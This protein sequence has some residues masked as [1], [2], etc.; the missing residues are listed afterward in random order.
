MLVRFLLAPTFK[1]QCCTYP[2]RVFS[3]W[4]KQ[5]GF[6]VKFHYKLNSSLADCDVLCI[7]HE[8]LDKNPLNPRPPDRYA[9]LEEFSEK[10]KALIWFDLS[11]STGTTQ[12]SVIP[13]VDLYAKNQLLKD[14]SLYLR[15][16]TE[17]R[18]FA[19]YYKE[20]A[21]V[22]AKKKLDKRQPAKSIELKKLAVSWNIGMGDIRRKP[23][24]ARYY[25]A[26]VP[27]TRYSKKTIP[28]R[29]S[30]DIDVAYRILN[31]QAVTAVSYQRHETGKLLSEIASAGK[32][33]ISPNGR[34]PFNK[35]IKEAGM[36][37]VMPSPFGN[38]EICFRDFECFFAGAALFKPDM[39]HLETW[40]DI[41]QPNSTYVPY[42]WD[43]ADFEERLFDLLESPEK[44][45]RIAQSGQER[46]LQSISP[47]GGKVFAQHFTELIQKAIDNSNLG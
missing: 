5:S 38:G 41:Y 4:I 24:L 47:G 32:Y 30:R 45:I 29:A 18:Y 15:P 26:I 19:D 16:F 27:W 13:F 14:R 6:R 17:N 21:S 12:F 34:I 11:D 3:S 44:R 31:R 8:A 25:S 42:A 10:T 7:C 39:G 9:L 23:G 22:T 35:Y 46:Y 28:I 33:C 1:S 37:K 2:I 40:P 36:A 43:F 20:F